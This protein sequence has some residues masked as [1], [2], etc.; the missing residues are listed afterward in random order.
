MILDF[1]ERGRKIYEAVLFVLLGILIVYLLIY[2]LPIRGTGQV[3]LNTENNTNTVTIRPVIE[4]T[5]AE[6]L[7]FNRNFISDVIDELK[8]KDDIWGPE[9]SDG[10]YV[11]VTFEQNLTNKNDI[12]IFPRVISDSPKIEVY[13][14]NS[15]KKIAEFSSLTSNEYNK[16]LLTNLKNSQDT[17]DLKVLDG[18]IEFNHIIDPPSGDLSIKSLQNGSVTL[19]ANPTTVT[20]NAVNMSQAFTACWFGTTASAANSVA[21]CN[22]T[23][24]TSLVVQAG[25]TGAVVGWYVIEFESGA[26]VQ[27]GEVAWATST[28][29]QNIPINS[30]D[31][32]KTFV[33]IGTRTTSTSATIDE[34][35]VTRAIL[36]N[37]TNLQLTRVET[38][39]A[40]THVWQVIELNNVTVQNGTTTLS[41]VTSATAAINS[42]NLSNTFLVFSVSGAAATNGVD[43]QYYVRGTFANSTAV[44]FNRN[45]ATNSVVV[46]W[47]AVSVNDANVQR[48]TSSATTTQTTLDSTI[49]A[50][51]FSRTSPFVSSDV[52]S[53]GTSDQDSGAWV[54]SFTNNTNIRVTRQSAQNVPSDVNWFVVGWPVVSGA[55]DSEAP[56][57]SSSSTN[58]TNPLPNA[59]VRHNILWTDT[60]TLAFATLE[61]N[62]SGASCNTAANVSTVSLS[63]SSAWANITWPVPNACEG[64]AIGWRQYG[65]DTM[66][67]MNT[68]SL[69]GYSVQNVNPLASFGTNPVDNFNSSSGSVTFELKGSDN[70]G[71]SFLRLYGN[72]S[73]SWTFNQTNAT[74]VNDTIW[75]VAV[76]GISEGRNH[77]WAA[78]VNDTSA[79]GNSDFTD[80]N[81]TFTVDLTN[82]TSTINQPSS[83]SFTNDNTP[84]INVTV[85][86]NFDSSITTNIYLNGS[87]NKTQAV[88]NNTATNITLSE[89]LSNSLWLIIAEA[90]DDSGRKTNSSTL[91]LTVDTI[92]PAITLPVYANAT[93]KKSSDILTLNISVSDANTA[94]T[95]CLVNVAGQGSNTTISY[96]S[97]WCNGTISLTGSNQGNST[98]NAYANDSAGNWGLNNSYVVWIDDTAPTIT[99]PTYINATIRRNDQSLTLNISVADSGVGVDK[100]IINVATSSIGNITIAPSSGWCNTTYALTGALDGNQTIN[101]YANDTVGNYGLNNSYV[102]QMDSTNP[103]SAINSP[104]N[105]TWVTDDTPDINITMTDN[106]DSSITY[107]IYVDGI[108]NKTGT[109]ANNT[110]T[111]VTLDQQPEGLRLIIAEAVDDAGNRVNS[112]I[113]F[114]KI[115]SSAPAINYVAPTEISGVTRSRNYIE[116]NVTATDTNLDK[117]LIRIYNSSNMQINSSITSASPNFI[118]FTGLSNGQYFYNATA[119]DTAG[120]TANVE[121]RNITLDTTAPNVQFV[122]NT[123]TS[124]SY[125]STNTINVNVTASDTSLDKIVT[126]LYNSTNNE[127]RNNLSSTSPFNITYSGLADGL[128]Y[129]NS[130]ANDTAANSNSTETRNVTIDT[131]NPLIQ[132]VAPTEA[133]GTTRTRTWIFANI[134]ITETNF[135]NVTFKLFNTTGQVN[136]TTFTDSRREI[137]FTGLPDGTYTYNVTTF[138]RASRSNNTETRYITLNQDQPPTVTI[139]Y[140]QNI[141][142]NVNVSELNYT[143]EDDISLSACWFSRDGGAT[144]SSPDFAPC[145]NFSGLIS[146]E[147]SNTW[148]VYA[149]DSLNQSGSA[150]VTFTKDTIFPQF[151]NHQ[152]NPSTPNEDQGVQVNVTVTETNKDKVI[153]EFNNGTARNY[154]IT[155]NNGDEFFFTINTG[156]Y[157]AHDSVNYSWYANDTAG[158]MNKSSLQS[159]TI[160]N[161]IPSVTA[162]AINDTTPETN[163]LISCNS[164]TFS[165]N[166]GEDTEQARFFRW[167]DNDIEISGQTSQTLSLTVS[168]LNKGDAIKC[169]TL[170]FDGFDNS[171]FVNSS[172]TAT[173]QNTAPTITNSLTSVSWNANGS[174][175]TYDYDATDSDGDSIIWYDNTTLFDINQTG[176]ISDIPTESEAGTY[177]IRI[178]AS[179]SAINATDDFTY[180]INDV[181]SPSIQFVSPTETN[182]S[183]LTRN[184][185][186][187]NVTA[188]DVNGIGTIT[189]KLY[190]STSLVQTSTSTTSPLFINFTSLPDEF[191]FFNAT[192]NDTSG[193]TNQTETRTVST[194]TGAPAIDYATPTETNNTYLGRNYIRINVTASD[195]N[196]DKIV[197]RLYNSTGSQINSNTTSTSPNFANFTGLADGQYKFNATAN[198]T[199]GNA[200]SLGT[201]N[202]TL[203]TTKPSITSMA[204]SPSDPATYVS[205]A[206]YRFN[207][208]ITDTNLDNVLIE[209]D[210]TNYTPG[211]NFGGGIYNFTISNLAAGVH[212]YYWWANDSAANVNVSVQTYTINNATGD[213][214]LLINGSATNQTAVYGIQTNAS[215][216]TLFG[217]I[218]LFR[219]GSDVT[220][221]NNAFVTLAVG[222]YNYTAVSSG[223]GNHSSASTSLFVTI[224]KANSQV[225]LTLNGTDGNVTIVQDSS[226]FLN[227]TT[228]TGDS[229]ATLRLYK[230]G[231]LINQGTSPLSNLTAFNTIGVF[232]ITGFYIDSEN[233]T[234]S[235]ETW[236]VNVTE[237]PDITAPGVTS[238]T[239][240]PSDP[241]TY[242]PG[243]TYEFNAT[244]TDNRNVSVVLIDFN[245][246][247][248][249]A[250]NLAGDIY[251]FTISDLGAGTRTY[252]WYAND[253]SGNMNSTMNGSYTINKNTTSL[254][255][256]ITPG[257]TVTYEAETTATGSNC[258]SQLTCILYRNGA[259]VSNPNTATLAVDVY[260]YT[261]NTTG[262]TNYTGASNSTNLTVNQNNG[263]CNVLF[264]ETSPI[265][266]PSMFRVFT[267]CTSGFTLFRNGTSISNNSEQAPGAGAYNFSVI[268]TDTQNY[269]NTFDQ[270]QFIINKATGVVFTYLDNARANKTIEQFTA[271]YINGTL[272]NG[273][274]TIKLYNNG[275]LINQGTSPLSNLTNFTIVGS[276]N[277]TTIYDGNANYTG[278]FETW[279]VNVT[280]LDVTPPQI[281]L[282]HPQ[283]ISYNSVQTQLNYTAS[284]NVGL[285][286]CWYSTNLGVTNTTITCGQ[287]IT[288]LS[289]GQGSS[290][291]KVY[292]ND[293]K[294]NQNS[295]S[296]TF[297]VDSINPTISFSTPTETSGSSLGRNYIQV[298]V[299]A[300]DTNLQ[301]ITI[302]LFNSTNHQIRSNVSTSPFFIN[303]TG[304]SA[305]NYSFNATANDSLNNQNSTE[306]RN[307]S[308]VVPTLTITRPE[309]KTYLT[310][311]NLQLNFTASNYD[312]LLYNIDNTANI[313]ITGNIT[314]NTTQGQHALYLFANNSVGLT[315]KNV[316][317]TVNSSRFV[318]YYSNYNGSEKGG[319]TDFIIYSYEDLQNL[320]G[321]VLENTDFGKINFN[322]A[323]NLTEDSDFSD[324][325]VDLDAYTNISDNLININTTALPNLNK[326][327]TLYLYGLTFSDPRILR[328]GELCPDTICTEINYSGGTLVF[329]VTQFT[330]YSAEETPS[331]GA[332]PSGGGGKGRAVIECSSDAE[333]NLDEQC[334][335]NKCVKLFD[336]KILEFESPVKLGDFFDFIY[337]IKG[338]AEIN[339]DVQ[340]D[341][342]IENA[343]GERITSGSD[344]IY[345]GNFEEK[346]EA[347]KIF[348][349]ASVD[350][351]IYR[352]FVRV[353]FGSYSVS[354]HRTIEIEVGEGLAEIK[355]AGGGLPLPVIIAI[356]ILLALFSQSKLK[357]RTFWK[358]PERKREIRHVLR[359]MKINTLP[360][361]PV[362]PVL[363]LPEIFGGVAKAEK[364]KVKHGPTERREEESYFESPKENMKTK[365]ELDSVLDKME[366][367]KKAREELDKILD[368]MEMEKRKK[369]DV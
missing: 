170:V 138:D 128:Y 44:V 232:N 4:I 151:T 281:S 178:S 301:N 242:S 148:T 34:Q 318:V 61:V 198:D 1:S 139:L 24:S 340:V 215:A 348:L 176:Y 160:A 343:Q 234:G 2:L 207:A 113:L 296:V 133:N 238:L 73:G 290:T 253:T 99:L 213:I 274:G 222:F 159:F 303:Y 216:S 186:Q 226:I 285:N 91:F 121:T 219:N 302:R 157:T 260:N 289:S 362:A 8:D 171:T 225:N 84:D 175:F 298:N 352:F 59:A 149:N 316:A 349:P 255:L 3:I 297:F 124:G 263:A 237:T 311:N 163:D 105:D 346:R 313:T 267:D 21:T 235:F 63:G 11:R 152:R 368:R 286:A 169:S 116:I 60:G 94:G 86:D 330:N 283:N 307:I 131:T 293:S 266:Y 125:K 361:V 325:A 36:T 33:L 347:T 300:T 365:E 104:G 117:I 47:F 309:N 264:N 190:N 67:N 310:A 179:D 315:A 295:S 233:Y 161:Q 130:T 49:T 27:R 214:T 185:L 243:V 227:A 39:I 339:G 58:D 230:A 98:I 280:E 136:V 110:P 236:Y 122:A 177:E 107:N 327:A 53:T 42:V 251:N 193:N 165:D 51:N 155:T 358:K 320:S 112:S 305:G 54:P 204:E 333:C 16:I 65:N 111:N 261:Y 199:F 268:R 118:N 304:L 41:A 78:W 271:I 70:L 14:K 334:I 5:S 43:A 154:T 92:S 357:R 79:N 167:F 294:G 172:N 147:G 95:S 270:E 211:N 37:S 328:D 212:N 250:T 164:G 32:T 109:I 158:N 337:L 209:F 277:I 127:I 319:S 203:D 192:V 308:L 322:Q 83:N 81:R 338:M 38:G 168:G 218:T 74:P 306:T 166:D 52:G 144:N 9:I 13:E 153:L 288:D 135:Q 18:S 363:N 258:P 146:N 123:E 247:N 262:N 239:E 120:N 156:N 194:D 174:T 48:G 249:T 31:L 189:L 89:A 23:S 259:S 10:E 205:G 93:K 345:L 256:A 141:I 80:T 248:H 173:I 145:A 353:T 369:D 129:F 342:W 182:A 278:D 87:L 72:W 272:E 85:A 257:T 142:Y 187:V 351:G 102:V 321:I 22:L 26:N 265:T 200:N 195:P 115:D 106:L 326:S 101:A 323:V 180:T 184:Y 220:S 291:W 183:Q 71:V 69:Q 197:I 201:R 162:P 269:S 15:D 20:I 17:F 28:A 350:S 114:L 50:I 223:D 75:S 329:N 202:V 103:T 276:Y 292:A 284:D 100:C 19:S 244:V 275:T 90:V 252:R 312:N 240:S 231:T 335:E 35:R 217:A 354:S 208:T 188:S 228:I 366:R 314:F 299:T 324:N 336:I 62:S 317:F 150:S 7:D 360:A 143:A 282:L 97:G 88:S 341:F 64:K 126:R 245:G 46:S 57:W 344:V 134:T 221:Q 6:H 196:L 40:V 108:I 132:F 45:S 224:S 355:G 55:P 279:Y 119:N 56:T 210:G 77:K 364:P 241:A 254:A 96:S 25:T 229:G 273:A 331:S 82:P 367:E 359:R 76:N 246:T 356:I 287:N 29:T 332:A 12:T 140:P 30:V 191:Y 181:S 206:T 137:N 66:G 68:T